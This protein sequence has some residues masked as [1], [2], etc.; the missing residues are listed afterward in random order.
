MIYQP[1][2]RRP[3]RFADAAKAQLLRGAG[4]VALGVTLAVVYI[5]LMVLA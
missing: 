5:V 2:L 4:A 1:P 3:T